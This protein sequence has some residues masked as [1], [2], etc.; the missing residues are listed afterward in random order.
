MT[1]AYHTFHGV[2]TRIV[3]IFNT[4]GPRMRLNDGRV[5]PAFMAQALLRQP[6]TVFGEGNQTRSFCYVSDL[7]EG[8]YRVLHSDSSAPFNVGNPHEFTIK[9]F[10]EQ[11]R[12][13]FAPGLEIKYEPLPVDDP[14]T[15]QPDISRARDLLG[16]QP[17]VSLE[18]GLDKAWA[19]FENALSK[20]KPGTTE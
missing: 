11:I 20:Q 7:V 10:A 4:Y 8:I 17:E 6:F 9:Q 12:D 5:V 2:E 19:Y 14:K 15:R 13:R 3:R 16:W 18:E 1:M